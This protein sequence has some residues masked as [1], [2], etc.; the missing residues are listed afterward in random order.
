MNHALEAVGSR[1]RAT[2]RIRQSSSIIGQKL[3][4]L[5]SRFCSRCV[6]QSQTE[7]LLLAMHFHTIKVSKSVIFSCGSQERRRIS[8]HLICTENSARSRSPSTISQLSAA[9]ERRLGR[10]EGPFHAEFCRLLLGGTW[11]HLFP[12]FVSS[13]VL[14]Y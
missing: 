8:Q 13:I 4:R 11:P 2:F 6:A 3:R 1:R 5:P 9:S 14:R 12:Q 7:T 10:S